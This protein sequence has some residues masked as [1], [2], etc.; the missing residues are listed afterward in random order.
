[1]IC[2]AR[3]ARRVPPASRRS[4]RAGR[5]VR[6]GSAS[7]AASRISRRR[8]RNASCP[9]SFGRSA[10][11]ISLRTSESRNGTSSARSPARAPA[12]CRGERPL[13]RPSRGRSRPARP[14][15]AVEPDAAA[16]GSSAARDL[17]LPSFSPTIASISSTKSGLP[18]AACEDPAPRLRREV[19]PTASSSRS[20][21]RILVGERLQQDRGRVQ[22][23]A[24]PAGPQVE[25]LR[26][27][28]AKEEDRGSRDQSA[29]CSTRSRKAGSAHWTSSSMTTCGARGACLEELA[30]REL[31]VRGRVAITSPGSRPIATR[32]STSGQY[33]MPSP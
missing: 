25:Q 23:A 4:A 30:K 27:S 22:L 19:A 21:L 24:A 16:P 28:D 8:K 33:V 29:T 17:A 18:S 2:P 20:E 3:Q 6:L 14:A 10:R 1:M 32:I 5:P 9:G 31:C 11:M 13:P 15:R 12:P 7:Y 26:A